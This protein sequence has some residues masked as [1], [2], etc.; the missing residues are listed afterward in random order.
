MIDPRDRD[1]NYLDKKENCGPEEKKNKLYFSVDLLS[2]FRW[3]KNK[4]NKERK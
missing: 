2:I 3:F 4:K 1:A